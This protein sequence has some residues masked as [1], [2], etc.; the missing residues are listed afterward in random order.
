MANPNNA[1]GTN[2][3]FGGRTSVNAF[4]D[5]LSAFDGRGV[6]SGWACTPNTGLTVNL[7]GNGS[8]RDVAIAEDVS[9]NKT[10]VN[11]IS[12][13]PI[14]VTV[15]AAPASNSRIDAIVAYIEDSPQGSGETDNPDVVN[16]L[17]VSGTVASTPTRPTDNA[18]RTAITTDGA[19]GATAYYVV[20]AYV[21]MA[22]GTT[23]ISAGMIAAGDMATLASKNIA[24]AGIGVSKIDFSTIPQPVSVVSGNYTSSSTS[25]VRVGQVSVTGLNPNWKYFVMMNYGLLLGSSGSVVFSDIS[26]DGTSDSLIPVDRMRG[27]GTQ[28]SPSWS[29]IYQP[30][31]SS[32]TLN[33]NG[34]TDSTSGSVGIESIKITFIPVRPIA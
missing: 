28:Q 34:R 29:T 5:V 25:R 23:D 32:I 16:M 9:G 18:I 8:V 27:G 31:S 14:S 6:L 21:T 17:V 4:N 19:S 33:I 30:K 12:Q 3:A 26:V 10:T 11:N 22:S 24:D 20:L 13:S 2:G 15:N 7:G 1:I